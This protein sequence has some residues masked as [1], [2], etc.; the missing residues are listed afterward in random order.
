ML[1]SHEKISELNTFQPSIESLSTSYATPLNIDSSSIL[2]VVALPREDDPQLK[3]DF[4]LF[5]QLTDLSI[6]PRK[7]G[8]GAWARVPEDIE[9]DDLRSNIKVF[10]AGAL[11]A[12]T[13]YAAWAISH[14]ARNSE[15]RQKLFDE[16]HEINRFETDLLES[17]PNLRNTLRE[18]LR[19][20]PSLYFLPRRAA[21]DTW[22][23]TD[24]GRRLWLPDGTHILLDVWHSNRLEEYW[25]REKTG[26][27]ASEFRPERWENIDTSGRSK[28][29]LHFGFGYGARVCPGQHLGELETALVVGGIVKLFEFEGISETVA[30]RAG[31]STKPADGVLVRLSLRQ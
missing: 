17:A 8:E 26:F 16:V 9:D 6:A 22:V 23:E 10:L 13:S 18:T 5:E 11:E 29:F 4:E 1:A 21:G 30:P 14:L 12:T 19:L 20:T 25:G 15:Y 27:P 3:E 31:V 7:S 28:E 24:D 2:L